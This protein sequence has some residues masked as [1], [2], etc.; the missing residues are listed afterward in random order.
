MEMLHFDCNNN[1]RL[2]EQPSATVLILVN[3]SSAR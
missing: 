3:T 1:D 2:Q